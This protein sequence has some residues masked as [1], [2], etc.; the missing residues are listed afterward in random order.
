VEKLRVYQIVRKFI[1][2][3]IIHPFTI[4][5][6]GIKGK[7]ILPVVN[8]NAKVKQIF[9]ISKFCFLKEKVGVEGVEPPPLTG[10]GFT[11]RGG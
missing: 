8:H 2:Y 1:L 9:D 11:D 6:I 10:C 7:R 3:S 5:L 4:R